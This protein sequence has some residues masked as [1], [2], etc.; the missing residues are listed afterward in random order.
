MPFIFNTNIPIVDKSDTI[1]L[2]YRY[3]DIIEMKFLF[4]ITGELSEKNDYYA[5]VQNFVMCDS[6]GNNIPAILSAFGVETKDTTYQEIPYTPNVVHRKIT[7][8]TNYTKIES[9]EYD[10]ICAYAVYA[11]TGTGSGQITAIPFITFYIAASSGIFDGYKTITAY[12]DNVNKTRII[13]I[14]K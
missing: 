12:F 9:K 7:L 10:F 13:K 11:S 8:R 3:N 5:G 1:T 2:Y 4:E 6:N 14:N